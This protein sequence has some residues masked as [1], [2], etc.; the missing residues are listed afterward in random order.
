MEVAYLKNKLDRLVSEERETRAQLVDAI[1]RSYPTVYVIRS[2]V[3]S[4]AGCYVYGTVSMDVALFSCWELANAALSRR[5]DCHLFEVVARPN[6][7]FSSA[8]AFLLV[9]TVVD[10][11]RVDLSA[12]I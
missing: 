3:L 10:D 12:R 5:K 6:N 8:S 11:F 2:K 7:M 9:D 1:K 4:S